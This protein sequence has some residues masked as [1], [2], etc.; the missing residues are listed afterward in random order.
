MEKRISSY[1]IDAGLHLVLI[2]MQIQ[3]QSENTFCA[4]DAL[5]DLNLI[6]FHI[7]QPCCLDS[8]L[9]QSTMSSY[10]HCVSYLDWQNNQKCMESVEAINAELK[11]SLATKSLLL[12]RCQGFS[13]QSGYKAMERFSKQPL[14]NRLFM[15]SD[16]A[17]KVRF[18]TEFLTLIR[19]PPLFMQLVPHW[20][21]GIQMRQN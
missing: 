5:N 7:S 15:R 21:T 6:E 20:S 2:V 8:S 9:T 17:N 4:S 12:E 19:R 14:L 11:F 18:T 1:T 16:Y 3:Q 10:F 13:G